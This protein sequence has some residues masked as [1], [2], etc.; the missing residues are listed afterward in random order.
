MN[1]APISFAC[2]GCDKSFTVPADKA[3]KTTKCPQCGE[4]IRIPNQSTAAKPASGKPAEAKQRPLAAKPSAERDDPEFI[5]ARQ[6]RSAKPVQREVVHV[7]VPVPVQV[8]VQQGEQVVRAEHTVR[9][10]GTFGSAFGG[11]MGILIAVSVFFLVV[12]G[13][14]IFVVCGGGLALFGGGVAAVNK[15]AENVL[16][17]NEE[18]KAKE[19]SAKRA[20]ALSETQTINGVTVEV[21]SVKIGKVDL[22]RSGDHTTSKDDA[23][24][25]SL[26][27]STNDP[28]KK[29]DHK[30]WSDSSSF[31]AHCSLKDNIGNNYKSTTYGLF[32]NIVGADMNPSITSREPAYDVIPFEVPVDGAS[33]LELTLEA[34]SLSSSEKFHFR[35]PK[36]LWL[37]PLAMSDSQTI[38]GITCT[39]TG[40][41]VGKVEVDDAGV[42]KRSRNDSL[43]I[44]LTI[45]T[46]DQSKKVTHMSWCNPRLLSGGSSLSDDSGNTLKRTN[47]TV[48]LAGADPYHSIT[49]ASPAHDVLSFE[50]PATT[51]NELILT[52]QEKDLI[53]EEKF[54]FRIPKALWSSSP[55][56]K[57]NG[58]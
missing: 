23:L 47:A 28:N 14:G 20:L 44:T 55:D 8:P 5:P 46:K 1:S 10:K 24:I 16:K 18:V 22:S 26:K 57:A 36:S 3:G 4:P 29:Y 11:T 30:S 13:I 51:A 15:A 50:V 6:P 37:K 35:I 19:K 17:E 21:I 25:V 39:I 38:N 56:Q 27:I 53:N 31:R 33:E 12:A 49:A 45:S 34:D 58:K 32:S 42:K 48:N 52:L 2:P 9:A 7:P 41:R 54:E 43:V 40:V